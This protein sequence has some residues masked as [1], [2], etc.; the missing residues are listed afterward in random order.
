MAWTAQSPGPSQHQ[1]RAKGLAGTGCK[2]GFL[3]GPAAEL[4]V[5]ALRRQQKQPPDLEW[6]LG[7][8]QLCSA[9]HSHEP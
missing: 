2:R 4:G 9:T 8:A 3:Q 1:P 5:S 6:P 7:P